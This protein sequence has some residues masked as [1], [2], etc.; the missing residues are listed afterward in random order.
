MIRWSSLKPRTKL[1][2]YLIIGFVLLLVW[3]EWLR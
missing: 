2:L 1:F 3:W